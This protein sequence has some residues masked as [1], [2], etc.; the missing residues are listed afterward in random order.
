MNFDCGGYHSRAMEEAELKCLSLV[1][2]HCDVAVYFGCKLVA[3]ENGK[4]ELFSTQT[5]HQV[6]LQNRVMTNAHRDT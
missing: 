5:A 6:L 3:I 4:H 2:I 1:V